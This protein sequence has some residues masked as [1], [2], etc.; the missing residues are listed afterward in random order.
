MNPAADIIIWIL[1]FAGTGFSALGFI[2]LLIFPDIR[3]RMYT[4]VRA[5]LISA[6]AF[7]SA[8]IIFGLN[9]LLEGSGYQYLTLILHTL[10]LF[11]VIVAASLVIS[12]IILEKTRSPGILQNSPDHSCGRG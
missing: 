9:A 2:A 5:T 12:G 3:S 7:S 4:A 11:C 6:A 8:V 10:F 1:L